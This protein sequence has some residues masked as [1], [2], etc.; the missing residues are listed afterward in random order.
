MG[1]EEE[2]VPFKMLCHLSLTRA[3]DTGGPENPQNPV[4]TRGRQELTEPF[5]GHPKEDAR[6]PRTDA[7]DRSPDEIDLPLP[8]RPEH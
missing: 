7:V 3:G 1:N 5:P 4:W 8:E 6:R 2:E